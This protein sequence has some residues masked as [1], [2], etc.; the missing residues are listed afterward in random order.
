MDQGG[1]LKTF[2][3]KSGMDITPLCVHSS[4]KNCFNK[5]VFLRFY[6]ELKFHILSRD[7]TMLGLSPGIKI[8]TS[9]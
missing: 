1:G 4:L 9:S 6:D 2:V 7:G 8:S 3:V 5:I